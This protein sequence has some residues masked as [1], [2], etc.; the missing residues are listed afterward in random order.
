MRLVKHLTGVFGLEKV[1]SR[2]LLLLC[3]LQLTKGA[4]L[5]EP[6]ARAQYSHRQLVGNDKNTFSMRRTSDAPQPLGSGLQPLRRCATLPEEVFSGSSSDEHLKTSFASEDAGFP[7]SVSYAEAC[8]G[9]MEI[10]NQDQ[11]VSFIRE[12][13]YGISMS[14]FNVRTF[15]SW[16]LGPLT[17][18]IPVQVP[19]HPFSHIHHLP[20]T[21]RRATVQFKC[22]PLKTACS[23]MPMVCSHGWITLN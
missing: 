12:H 14:V 20:P 9:N 5:L 18:A 10:Q 7:V 23:Q 19:K 22:L 11:P 4:P 2:H 15:T 6:R 21:A 3:Q 1:P 16:N 17:K 8:D 13:G